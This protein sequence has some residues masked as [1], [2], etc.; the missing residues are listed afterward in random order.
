P[1]RS[2]AASG[3]L[4]H[5]RGEGLNIPRL[6]GLD[7]S[8]HQHIAGP[9][10]ESRREIGDLLP[11]RRVDHLGKIV[12]RAAE[13]RRGGLRQQHLGHAHHERDEKQQSGHGCG[14]QRSTY[15]TS[16]SAA[17]R[18]SLNDRAASWE[19]TAL[20]ISPIT[21][22]IDRPWAPPIFACTYSDGAASAMPSR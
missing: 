6:H 20:S 1:A 18:Y 14:V 5:L 4:E 15:A 7:R 22:A 17:A 9:L 10:L 16:A 13:G 3:V 8:H 19:A 11:G 21:A 2:D 12:D